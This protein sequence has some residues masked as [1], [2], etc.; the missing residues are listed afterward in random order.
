MADDDLAARVRSTRDEVQH[1][2]V[3][4]GDRDHVVAARASEEA[5]KPCRG[6]TRVEEVAAEPNPD[7]RV[8]RQGR[9]ELLPHPLAAVA[10][11][12]PS[13]GEGLITMVI[14]AAMV[15]DTNLLLEEADE[16]HS[17]ISNVD[18]GDL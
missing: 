16:I 11:P 14:M 10:V 1:A 13:V 17:G 6:G 15:I 9:E 7:G 18:T 8:G 12:Y 2:G 4:P 3:V 5:Q